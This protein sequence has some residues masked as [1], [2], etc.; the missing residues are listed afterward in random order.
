MKNI[1][2]KIKDILYDGTEYI[3]MIAIIAVVV[4]VINW[5]LEGL[6]AMDIESSNVQ[7]EVGNES[8]VNEFS[9][10]VDD[11][12]EV[13]EKEENEN[14]E[15]AEIVNIEIPSGTLPGEI[16]NILASNYLI[17]SKDEFI[18]K[19]IEMGVETKL[20]SGSFKIVK[21]SSLEEIINTL[22]K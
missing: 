2:D 14:S 5:R 20:K 8:V 4:L 12:E 21:G 18:N 15:E 3:L 9:D 7:V 16:G 13:E 17:D 10:Y 1:M 6:F 22:T 19:V 11:K